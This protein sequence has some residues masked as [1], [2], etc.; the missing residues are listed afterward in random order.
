MAK[1]LITAPIRDRGWILPV[2]MQSIDVVAQQAQM[3]G[4]HVACLF[5]END[6]VD[7][8]WDQLT[9]WQDRAEFP[10]VLMQM[11]LG[12]EHYKVGFRDRGG[13]PNELDDKRGM[14]MLRNAILDAALGNAIQVVSDTS[15]IT[16]R[17]PSMSVEG[18]PVTTW[19]SDLDDVYSGWDYIVSIDSDVIPS[20]SLLGS[21][22][23][24]MI[25]L[26][27]SMHLKVQLRIGAMVFDVQH[28]NCRGQYHNAMI[29]TRPGQYNHPQRTGIVPSDRIL[30]VV[31]SGDETRPVLAVNPKRIPMPWNPQLRHFE[32]HRDG[33]KFY[34][35]RVETTG[36]GGAVIMRRSA[37]LCHLQA[38][39][40]GHPQ[41]EDIQMCGVI[42]QDG[43]NIATFS[44][45][46]GLHLWPQQREAVEA[47]SEANLWGLMHEQNPWGIWV[48]DWLKW[49][50]AHGIHLTV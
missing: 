15:L 30:A 46:R 12:A 28:P 21:S 31:G 2:W 49:V 39:Y 27:E 14:A 47:V 7:D 50:H 22:W 41:G 1:I 29:E 10:I 20:P 33:N 32:W 4:H 44:G 43:W 19:P 6:S 5:L 16:W 23:R 48:E 13:V 37:L 3:A 26:M 36:G 38:R 9:A 24:S 34:V 42:R 35:A 8:T 11:N 17:W 25:T 40:A 18:V 45:Q